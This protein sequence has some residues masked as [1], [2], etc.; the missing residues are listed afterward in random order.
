MEPQKTHENRFLSLTLFAIGIAL[1]LWKR[2]HQWQV[3]GRLSLL[4]MD[5][6][7]HQL[8]DGQFGSGNAISTGG[9]TSRMVHFGIFETHIEQGSSMSGKSKADIGTMQYSWIKEDTGALRQGGAPTTVG[10]VWKRTFLGEYVSVL[11]EDAS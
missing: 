10:V 2:C 9:W 4:L 6:I 7:L 5:E 1:L 11:V 3:F 8:L